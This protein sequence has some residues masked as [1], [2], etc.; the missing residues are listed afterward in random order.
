MKKESLCSYIV[1]QKGR[2]IGLLSLYHFQ[3]RRSVE[4][5]LAILE[6][7][8]RRRGYGRATF[9]LFINYFSKTDAAKEITVTIAPADA[10]ACLFW[11][12][13]GFRETARTEGAVRL[14]RP[15]RLFSDHEDRDAGVPVDDTERNASEEGCTYRT[16][17]VGSHDDEVRL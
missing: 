5:G 12:R 17:A 1:R 8:D 11:K 9:E 2:R 4:M 7:A 6:R 3:P 16:S 15:V 10:S 14:L 13:L